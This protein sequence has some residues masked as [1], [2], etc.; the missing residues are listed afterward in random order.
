MSHFNALCAI[1]QNAHRN[2]SANEAKQIAGLSHRA[3]QKAKKEFA[4]PLQRIIRLSQER[5]VRLILDYVL[6]SR[7][8]K[9]ITFP[10]NLTFNPNTQRFQPTLFLLFAL[11]EIDGDLYPLQMDFWANEDWEPD[12]GL[13]LTKNDVAKSMIT[14]LVEKGLQFFE[15]LFDAGFP[16]EDLLNELDDL[17]IPY[18]CRI[19][20]SWKISAYGLKR[21]AKEMFN[22]KR[23]FYFDRHQGCFLF[24]RK[25]HFG[26]H[27]VK[28][29]AVANTREKL[30]NKKFYCL[31]TNRKE[32]KHT[33]IL[34]DY[35]K[36]GKIEWF[37][38]VM[39]SYL[40]LAAFFRHH[41][42]ESLLP[43]FHLRCAAFVLLQSYAK[44]M[45]KSLFQALKA[46]KKMTWEEVQNSLMQHWQDWSESL[47]NPTKNQSERHQ[48]QVSAA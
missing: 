21:S 10:F 17:N 8:C 30:L 24:S 46:L 1:L 6:I 3:F 2:L 37:F 9:F 28:L 35:Q 32:L 18:I 29:V 22:K 41:P 45:S 38:K 13:Y 5:P 23:R 26:N 31:L 4:M 19:K 16:S 47:M 7:N 39:K 27:E 34:R 33:Q 36:R 44:S 25:G 11:A 43:H 15:V 40:G 12:D 20:S 14:G 48:T 42:D